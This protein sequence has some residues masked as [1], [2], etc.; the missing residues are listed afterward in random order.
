M[1]AGIYPV[2]DPVKKRIITPLINLPILMP[3]SIIRCLKSMSWNKMLSIFNLQSFPSM[4]R[5]MLQ[6]KN[7]KLN[8]IPSAKANFEDVIFI[9]ILFWQC[10]KSK[11]IFIW[12]IGVF[13]PFLKK[14]WSNPAAV[15]LLAGCSGSKADA[16]SIVLHH[17]RSQ[18]RHAPTFFRVAPTSF[19]T[20]FTKLRCN[21]EIFDDSF[22]S[23]LHYEPIFIS[24]KS[25]N[26]IRVTVKQFW[27]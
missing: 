3:L 14:T 16:T 4:A 26:Y 1:D 21:F 13:Q 10:F 12:L 17:R 22:Y 11:L 9:W 7:E 23:I 24:N 5:M 25:T 15:D 2:S 8:T 20:L 6:I 19:H 27:K 18:L